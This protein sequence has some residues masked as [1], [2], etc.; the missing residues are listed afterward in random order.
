[1][2]S[3]SDDGLL[4]LLKGRSASRLPEVE[5]RLA[6]SSTHH[7]PSNARRILNSNANVLLL[8]TSK[9]ED[10]ETSIRRVACLVEC[11]HIDWEIDSSTASLVPTEDEERRKTSTAFALTFFAR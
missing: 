1:M 9:K 11:V 10:V 4:S 2:Y 7:S 5:V 6:A 8:S 3:A